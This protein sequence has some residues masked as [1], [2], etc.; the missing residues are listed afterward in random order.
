MKVEMNSTNNGKAGSSAFLPRRG[1]QINGTVSR[2]AALLSVFLV[3]GGIS[4]VCAE[5][6]T[7]RPTLSD[8]KQTVENAVESAYAVHERD[9]VV[10][11]N[12][13]FFPYCGHGQTYFAS[14]QT[15]LQMYLAALYIDHV[16]G[17]L[18]TN[19]DAFCYFTVATWRDAA[20]LDDGFRRVTA[21]GSNTYGYAQAGDEIGSWI[22]E[23]IQKGFSA[24]KYT[25][26]V[27]M[28]PQ[29]K[30][31]SGSGRQA[32]CEGARQEAVTNYDNMEW[33]A[34]GTTIWEF[35]CHADIY[36]SPW[37]HW[38]GGRIRA[39]PLFWNFPAIDRALDIYLKVTSGPDHTEGFI[40][41][42]NLGIPEYNVWFLYKSIP[43]FDDETYQME[44]I[45][46]DENP[47]I[48]MNWTCPTTDRQCYITAANVMLVLAKWDFTHE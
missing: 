4:S 41:P 6:F 27:A 36:I 23:D 20:G 8:L 30:R 16:N 43:Q 17:P 19:Q 22:F 3:Y 5:D 35:K 25:R 14:L 42:D 11:R 29:V 40:D 45:G 44:P 7:G 38:E 24:L 9:T 1:R 47:I 28:Y 13:A 39:E 37:H 26:W 12:A 18:T 33:W 10:S 34:V 31:R 46:G 21:E 2:A 32:W 15:E 48:V